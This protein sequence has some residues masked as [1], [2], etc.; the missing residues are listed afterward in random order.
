MIALFYCCF[1][2]LKLE[3][4]TI[5]KM[6]RGKYLTKLAQDKS[7]IL[8]NEPILN[9]HL[10]TDTTCNDRNTIKPVS[11]DSALFLGSCTDVIQKT[12]TTDEENSNI[13]IFNIYDESGKC[14]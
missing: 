14:L 8:Q 5:S 9:N 2:R 12:Q 3:C 4:G 11:N 13:G 7:K 10:K 1:F 6:N